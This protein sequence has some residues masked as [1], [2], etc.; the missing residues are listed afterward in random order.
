MRAWRGIAGV[1]SEILGPKKTAPPPPADY[2]QPLHQKAVS[3]RHAQR[4]AAALASSSDTGEPFD[5]ALRVARP[6][7]VTVEANML[8]G[9]GYAHPDGIDLAYLGSV[10]SDELLA[11]VARGARRSGED[12]VAFAGE[13]HS[14]RWTVVLPTPAGVRQVRDTQAQL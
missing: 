10:Q 5:A 3:V 13:T 8:V 14:G 11:V 2:V 7:F 12:M 4:V 1:F 6:Q 9:M